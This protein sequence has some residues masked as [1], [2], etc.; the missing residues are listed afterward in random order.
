MV[1][2]SEPLRAAGAWQ[3]MITRRGAFVKEK[4]SRFKLRRHSPQNVV[5]KLLWIVL[6]IPFWTALGST[7]LP[8]ADWSAWTD[9][10]LARSPEAAAFPVDRAAAA[11]AKALAERWFPGPA[12]AEL[13]RRDD[14]LQRGLGGAEQELSLAVPLWLPGERA[15]ARQ[16]AETEADLLDLGALQH[17]RELA[18][19]L[20]DLGLRLQHAS[21]LAQ[22]LRVERR[23]ARRFAAEL[24]QAVAV[25]E[26]ALLEQHRAEA[27]ALQAEQAAS[28]VR[29]ELRE[30][31]AAWREQTGLEAPRDWPALPAA[32]PLLDTPELRQ[33]AARLAQAE[34]ALAQLDTQGVEAPT[35]ALRWQREREAAGQAWAQSAG[36]ALSVPL[37]ATRDQRRQRAEAEARR[38]VA[39]RALE[40]ARRQQDEARRL[41]TA[42]LRDA[43][44]ERQQSAD[45]VRLWQDSL[46]WTER[47]HAL[48]EIGLTE[49]MMARREQQAAL[50]DALTREDA[51]RRAALA[52]IWSRGWQP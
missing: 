42:A 29:R 27:E 4:S 30:L 35:L 51:Y 24:A 16:L 48:G 31:R 38:E 14:R 45:R 25:G 8:A 52:L 1:S 50:R 17:R 3:R 6:L 34:A 11:S 49:L 19:Q 5:M 26:R 37:G 22:Q 21:S 28:A 32:V 23:L 40:Q 20:L 18:G 7:S 10:A 13:A 9:R 12:T 33:A 36:L 47:A 15:A 44:R 46:A 39:L 41:A 43:E 2:L